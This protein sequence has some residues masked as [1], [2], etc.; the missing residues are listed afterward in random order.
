MG[1]RVLLIAESGK[2]P[3]A[4]HNDY[5]VA[6]TGR[7]EEYSDSPVSGTT[8]PSGAYLLYINDEI[9]PEDRV[10][11]K[12][13]ANTS[14][15]ACYA[16][17]TSMNSLVCSWKNGAEEWSVFHDAATEGIEHIEITGDA[18]D[19][20]KAIQDRLFA[21]RREKQDADYIFDIPI[22]LFVALG[23]IRYDYNDEEGEAL[24]PKP[25]HVLTRVSNTQKK[26]WWWPFS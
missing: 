10:F 13:S 16:N 21:E 19:Q 2:D 12:L 22:E 26:K 23:G 25:W 18:P 20:L 1:F 5:G 6:P 14:L 17:E 4:I 24:G 3:D 11:A 8:L 15:I 9:L 7:F